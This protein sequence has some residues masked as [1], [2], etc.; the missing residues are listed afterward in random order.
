MLF[1]KKKD[2]ISESPNDLD[3]SLKTRAS[4]WKKARPWDSTNKKF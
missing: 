1:H 4:F 2:Q 3:E